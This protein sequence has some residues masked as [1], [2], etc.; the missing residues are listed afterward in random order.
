MKVLVLGLWHLGCV[1]AASCAKHFDVV[2]LEDDSANA[3]ALRA[4]RL[5]VR[6]PDLDALFKRG[7]ASGRLRISAPSEEA[8]LDASVLWVTEDT[9]VDEDDRPDSTYVINRVRNLVPLLPAETVVLISAQLPA[10][11]CRQ[12]EG[13]FPGRAFA[14]SPEN[15]RLGR[16]ILDFNEPDRIIVG[17]RTPEVRGVLANLF[18]SFCAN[19]LWMSPES[20]E[21]TKHALNAFLAV[22]VT[23]AN[24][25]ARVCEKQVRT[26]MTLHSASKATGVSAPV[27]TWLPAPLLPA[28]HLRGT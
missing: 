27:L 8:C 1:T 26:R 4:G 15:L 25:I 5:P 22:S 14:C 24:E 7:L 13:E 9:P 19:I 2:C 11:S 18:E 21:M 17:C 3:D 16:S 28:E 23:F 12:L 6:E 20:A 10:G